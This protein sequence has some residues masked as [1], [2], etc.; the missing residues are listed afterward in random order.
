MSE[1]ENE[2]WRAEAEREP[3]RVSVG[4]RASERWAVIDVRTGER[5]DVGLSQRDACLVADRMNAAHVV[6][7]AATRPTEEGQ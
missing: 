4:V 5:V 7:R 3:F 1:Q 6:A 2:D